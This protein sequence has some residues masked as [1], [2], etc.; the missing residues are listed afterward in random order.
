MG[1]DYLQIIYL[2]GVNIQHIQ[3]THIAQQKMKTTQ[4]KSGQRT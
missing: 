3:I 4:L 2:I 1:E